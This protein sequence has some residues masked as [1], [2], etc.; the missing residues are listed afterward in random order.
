M[1]AMHTPETNEHSDV[2]QGGFQI[3]LG[4]LFLIAIYGASTFGSS[5][6]LIIGLLPI[7]W[8]GLKAYN[9]YKEDGYLSNRV[10][11]GL[12]SC[13]FPF[14]FIIAIIVGFDMSRLW[15]IAVILAGATTILIN[16][17]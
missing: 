7:Y 11:T 5:I 17:R 6:W 1:K 10:L 16:R 3:F 9:L 14:I 13:L 4:I 15:P 12:V 8:I 2:A